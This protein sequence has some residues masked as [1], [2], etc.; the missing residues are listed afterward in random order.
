M[1]FLGEK[2][3]RKRQVFRGLLLTV[4]I[5]LLVMSLPALKTEAARVKDGW[6][7]TSGKR[8]YYRNQRLLKGFQ[9]IKKNYYYFH[10]TTGA[11][12]VNRWKKINGKWYY[13]LPKGKMAKK[14]WIGN[15][16][17]LSNG[18]MATNR[19]IGKY[20]VGEDGKWIPNFKAGWHK[21][22]GNWY[23]YT[24]TGKKKTGWITYKGS[25]YYL[26]G[27]GVM[28]TK[29]QTIRSKVYFFAK[30]GNLKKNC[31]VKSGGWYYWANSNGQLNTK[32][33]MN[34]KSYTTATRIQ[35]ASP[36]FNAMIQKHSGYGTQYWIARVKV[37]SGTKIFKALSY[38][39]YGGLLQKTTDAVNYFG[40]VLGVNGSRFNS[41]GV[42]S[43]DVETLTNGVINNRAYGV[44]HGFMAIRSDGAMYM[45]QVGTSAA[46]LKKQGVKDTFSFG[47]TLLS[48]GDVVPLS[49]QG[50]PAAFSSPDMQGKY[51]RTAVGMVRPGEYVLLVTHARP[52]LTLSEMRNIFKNQGCSYAFNMDGGGSATLSYRGH[53]LNRPTDGTERA[54]GDFLL[55]RE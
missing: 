30:S 23:Y 22:G 46:S 35:Y 54:V 44:G 16:Y 24:K 20:F 14:R 50:Y 49:A 51:P 19:W 21:I 38:G 5:F 42:P 37:N 41:Y 48:G 15:Y 52:G 47:P 40:A 25:R 28:L 6:V 31:W 11:A 32:E 27:S 10:T 36:G 33:K 3:M 39:S 2:Q 7:T 4:C 34:T 43:W 53:L 8:Y 12:L 9:K 13:F 1:I 18:V 29:K 45:P 17:V 26:N 55:F